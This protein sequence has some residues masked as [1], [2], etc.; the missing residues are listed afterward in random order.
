MA[1]TYEAIRKGN[2]L[3][4]RWTTRGKWVFDANGEGTAVKVAGFTEKSVQLSGNPTFGEGELTIQGSMDGDDWFTLRDLD[5][6]DMV[7]T[8]DP[9]YSMGI[10]GLCVYVRPVLVGA[11]NP[12]LTLHLL[13][14][15]P[16]AR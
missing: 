14:I 6:V 4:D 16:A 13:A 1:N 3:A 5:G 15:S 10:W 7:W 12:N 2:T 8:A 11:T 9:S